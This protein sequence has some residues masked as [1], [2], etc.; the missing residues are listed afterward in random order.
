ME[1][2][3]KT[4]DEIRASITDEEVQHYSEHKARVKHWNRIMWMIVALMGYALY[5]ALKYG[6][7][8]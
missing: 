5:T 3:E 2:Q 1:D 4:D 8:E 7:L 6:W